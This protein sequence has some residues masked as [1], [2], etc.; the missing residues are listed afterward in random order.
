MER[1]SRF[2]RQNINTLPL[3]HTLKTPAAVV[4]HAL[5]PVHAHTK[6]S[7]F[8]Q[9]DLENPGDPSP[10]ASES[11]THIQLEAF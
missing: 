10:P 5:L 4:L 6:E 2:Q 1:F 11:H 8:T 9:R 3:T 7:C